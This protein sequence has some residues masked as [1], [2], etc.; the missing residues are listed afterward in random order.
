MLEADHLDAFG[1]RETLVRGSLGCFETR[2][3]DP[4]EARLAAGEQ[5]GGPGWGEASL[6]QAGRLRLG[7]QEQE[8]VRPLLPGDHG[9]FYAG[10]AA[11]ILHGAPPPVPLEDALTQL[12][13]IEAALRSSETGA[14][15]LLDAAQEE[16]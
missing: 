6:S 13:I 8:E 3:L 5:P 7:S 12:Q 4:Q 15:V 1:G 16:R 14:A 11:A 9:L 2:G 10:V